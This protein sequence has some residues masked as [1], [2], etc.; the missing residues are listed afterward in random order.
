MN[1]RAPT[2]LAVGIIMLNAISSVAEETISTYHT[3]PL[4]IDGN[5]DKPAWK[6][7]VRIPMVY[8]M[9]TKREEP[10]ATATGYYMVAW[11]E[12][13]LYIAYDWTSATKP[14]SAVW[15]DERGPRSNPRPVVRLNDEKTQFDCFEFFISLHDDAFHFWELQHNDRNALGDYFCIKPRDKDDPLRSYLDSPR[16]PVVWLWPCYIQD[17]GEYTVKTA[18]HEKTSGETGKEIYSGYSAELRLPLKSIGAGYS[19]RRENGYQ[20]AGA[21]LRAFGAESRNTKPSY[22]HSI[23]G[24]HDGWFHDALPRGQLFVFEQSES[25]GK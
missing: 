15:Q 16:S 20:L 3:A 9:F 6:A 19:L 22:F 12:H 1:F 17:D 13:Y 8:E 23:K 10:N 7:A 18:V 2:T 5:L 11:D 14:K 4:T 25:A 21:K 24:L